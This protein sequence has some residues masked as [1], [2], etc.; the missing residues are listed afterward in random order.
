MRL[1]DLIR[2]LPPNKFK[3]RSFKELLNN[4]IALDKSTYLDTILPHIHEFCITDKADGVRTVVVVNP[5]VALQSFFVN[6][7]NSQ[8]PLPFGIQVPRR[9][10]LLDAELLDSGEFLVFDVL[11][12]EGKSLTQLPFVERSKYLQEIPKVRSGLKLHAKR[13]EVLYKD[14][15]AAQIKQFCAAL[16][17]MPYHTDGIIFTRVTQ[18]YRETTSYKWKPPEHLTIDFLAI[19]TESPQEFQLF[20]GMNQKEMK[21]FGIVLKGDEIQRL[22]ALVHPS[23]DYQPVP[24]RPS[25]VTA[26]ERAPDRLRCTGSIHGKIVECVWKGGEWQLVRVRTDRDQELHTGGYF[27]N[28]FRLAEFTFMTIVHP[29][30]LDFLTATRDSLTSHNYFQKTDDE[31]REVRKFNNYIKRVCIRNTVRRPGCVV[32]LASGKGQDLNKY[33][34]NPNIP[35]LIMV[36]VDQAGI[37][38]I[39]RR[40][41]SKQSEVGTG[42]EL[43]VIEWD[44][45]RDTRGLTAQILPIRSAECHALFCH[46]A[47]HY[48][49]PDKKH[50]ENIVNFV[51]ETLAKED[52]E[53]VFTAFDGQRV[54]EWLRKHGGKWS[55]GKFMIEAKYPATKEIFSGFGYTIRVLLPCSPVPY[56]ENLID[57]VELD[58][59]FHSKG[60]LRTTS[61]SFLDY[62]QTARLDDVNQLSQSEL[63][64]ISLYGVYS[65]KR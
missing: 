49:I 16:A 7:L 19:Q 21:K 53:F 35:Q 45:L 37:D 52:G 63:D 44:L 40:K 12:W 13:F 11:M 14:R 10:T 2:L 59:M 60:M 64:F 51:A 30:T 5:D 15:Y 39:I 57:I 47:L 26:A 32:D 8:D 55:E 20:C 54:F 22:G 28:N 23:R 41:H 61:A 4:V 24:F 33:F 38:E 27:G 65:Y 17:G 42:T 18:G 46:F 1:Y 6:G 3:P 50:C 58:K 56:E 9:A 36:E 43:R 48:L 29:I 34:G 62:L 25:L 31:Y